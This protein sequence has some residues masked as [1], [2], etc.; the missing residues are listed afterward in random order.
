[1]SRKESQMLPE[2]TTAHPL[3]LG[4][5]LS[6]AVLR[7][8]VAVGLVLVLAGGVGV[9][10]SLLPHAVQSTIGRV[11]VGIGAFGIVVAGLAAIGLLL[12]PVLRVT[13]EVAEISEV[14]AGFEQEDLMKVLKENL[15]AVRMAPI[16]SDA[17]EIA[18]SEV[19]E[20]LGTIEAG[21]RRRSG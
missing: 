8:A 19:R 6:S 17:V 12:L 21:E 13:Q 14:S 16:E 2:A 11:C 7:L 4:R 18:M 5:A 10:L 15:E 1:M 9:M 3:L 20:M